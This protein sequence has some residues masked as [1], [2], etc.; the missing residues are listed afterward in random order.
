MP[1]AFR[2]STNVPVYTF[3][4]THLWWSDGP[5]LS[6]LDLATFENHIGASFPTRVL[7]IDANDSWCVVETHTVFDGFMLWKSDGTIIAKHVGRMILTRNRV[8]YELIP[9]I[10]SWDFHGPQQPLFTGRL[11]SATSDQLL[12]KDSNGILKWQDGAV[13]RSSARLDAEETLAPPF[14]VVSRED[15]WWIES[16]H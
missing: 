7:R 2:L 8:V 5:D 6:R 4:S 1:R 15:G 3:T 11:Q 10:M 13:A 9:T 14:K 12:Y 16:N